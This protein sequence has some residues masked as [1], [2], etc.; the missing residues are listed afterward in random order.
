[1]QC[2]Y[3]FEG[4]NLDFEPRSPSELRYF[5]SLGPPP[6]PL[7]RARVSS[8]YPCVLRVLPPPC[9]VPRALPHSRVCTHG[10]SGVPSNYS[11]AVSPRL[12]CPPLPPLPRALAHRLTLIDVV[13][14]STV[15]QSLH[16]YAYCP[17]PPL[18]CM[19]FNITPLTISGTC[20]IF[21]KYFVS[22]LFFTPPPSSHNI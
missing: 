10:V 13:R 3:L 6:R 12:S 7:A 15:V 9:T 1:M 20:V 5:R 16:V 8:K 14:D 11:P 4:R 21:R 17:P 2:R 22:P 18:V 19:R